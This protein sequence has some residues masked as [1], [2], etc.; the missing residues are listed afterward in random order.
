MLL[1]IQKRTNTSASQTIPK[2]QEKGKLPSSLYEASI[3][4]IPKT[5][6]DITKKIIGQYPW[7]KEMQKSST[8]Y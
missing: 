3:L 2:I 5:D 7:W 6:K 8:K 4:L 1:N